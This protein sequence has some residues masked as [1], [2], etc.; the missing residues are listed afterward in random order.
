MVKT[1]HVN[2]D[3]D[4]EKEKLEKYNKKMEALIKELKLPKNLKIDTSDIEK[5]FAA[6]A[7]TDYM[8]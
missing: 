2:N 5:D 1:I 3:I 6:L 4:K 7:D 8:K